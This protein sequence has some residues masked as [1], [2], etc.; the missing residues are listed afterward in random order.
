MADSSV[1]PD[2]LLVGQRRSSD[3]SPCFG[4]GPSAYIEHPRFTAIVQ[5]FKDTMRQA[6]QLTQRLRA[7]PLPKEIIVNDDS[8]GAQHGY[9]LSMLTGPNELYISSPNLHEV[10]AYNRVAAMARGE[11][12]VFVQG[13]CCL[14]ARPAWMIDASRLFAALPR[15]AML[16]AR[17][18]FD[19]VL[20]WKMDSTYRNERTWGAAPYKAIDHVAHVPTDNG[21]VEALPFT[22]AAGVDSGPLIYRR[23]ALLGIGG[24]DE[25]YSCAAGHV[26]G[27][28]DFEASLRFWSRGWQVGVFYGCS[29]N[30]MGGRKTIR[31]PQKKTERHK[32]EEW[33]GLRVEKLW[34]ASNATI[35]Q[36]LAESL[37]GLAALSAEARI[38]MRQAREERIGKLTKQTCYDGIVRG[39]T[40]R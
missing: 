22:F 20:N 26:S 37:R 17:A 12:L 38:E 6:Q 9:W 35:A 8:H 27:H 19:A 32:N 15:L 1:G 11:L 36:H 25:S 33:N 10:R 30:G 2:C 29:T 23:A 16:S 5:T 21:S 18:G 40:S 4:G 34:R 39:G 3:P 28:Y 31:T 24:F 7:I 13:D 14:P